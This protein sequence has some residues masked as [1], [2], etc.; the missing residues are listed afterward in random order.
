MDVAILSLGTIHV[1]VQNNA[2]RAYWVTP[3]RAGS[4]C[5]V[6]PFPFL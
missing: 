5:L 6:M 3:V 1:A 2:F 4:I